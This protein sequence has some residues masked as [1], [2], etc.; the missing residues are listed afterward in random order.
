MLLA[1]AGTGTGKT[2]AY[3]AARGG[4]GPP[5][6]V[7]TGTKNLQEQLLNKD[8]PL[9]ARALGR[10]LSVAVM[11]GRGELPL[12]PALQ[13][14]RPGRQLP[15][16]R[17]DP[18]LPRR[19]GLGAADGDGRPRRDRGPARRR[20]LLARDLRGQREL[21]RPGLPRLRPLLGDAHAPA[22]ARSRPRGR[23][24]SPALRRPRGEG[25]A[26][27][28]RDPGLRHADPGRGPPAGGRGHPVLRHPGLL[29]PRRGP[30]PR[31]GARAQGRAPRRARRA[32]AS[33]TPCAI[34]RERF[35]KMRRAGARPP[36]RGGLDAAARGR[37]GGGAA[38]R[39]SRDCAPRSW[40]CPSGPEP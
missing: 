25:R 16:P 34:A 24:P 5:R 30:L 37:G 12:P 20:R 36:P 28:A 3:L 15:A 35:F 38:G 19:R 14:V 1:E 31:R 6:R 17:R 33:S 2:L 8:I 29:A 11:K 13:V 26:A 9:L 23:E 18:A 32:R 4:A 7:S 21:H 39:A 27:T 22:R 40:P 10:D